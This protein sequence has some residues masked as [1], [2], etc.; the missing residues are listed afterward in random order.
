MGTFLHCHHSLL[1]GQDDGWHFL[2]WHVVDAFVFLD[3]EELC[4][5]VG[6]LEEFW[7]VLCGGGEGD[8]DLGGSVCGW[9]L[10]HG[11]VLQLVVELGHGG[12]DVG[13]TAEVHDDGLWL[14]WLDGCGSVVQ[15][16]GWGED[17]WCGAGFWCGFLLNCDDSAWC[18]NNDGWDFLRWKVFNTGKVL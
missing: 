3:G 16:C 2:C 4:W 14:V 9:V 7:V 5:V 13:E 6:L 1:G 18:G 17:L 15:F 10:V 11:G 8:D 12:W